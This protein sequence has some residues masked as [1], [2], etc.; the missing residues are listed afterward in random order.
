[1][2]AQPASSSL[3]LAPLPPYPSLEPLWTAKVQRATERQLRK[4]NT[5]EGK[6]LNIEMTA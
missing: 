2:G 5:L 1:M 4:P 3:A 6:P